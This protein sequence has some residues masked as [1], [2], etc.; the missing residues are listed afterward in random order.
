MNHTLWHIIN[1]GQ[2]QK[3]ILDYVNKALPAPTKNTAEE[4]VPL[5]IYPGDQVLFG[6]KPWRRDPQKIN[7]CQNG[8]IPT[9]QS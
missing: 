8:I 6:L 3:A 1:G 5:Q 7:Y 4:A 9:E 2:I